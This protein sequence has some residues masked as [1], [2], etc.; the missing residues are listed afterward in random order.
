MNKRQLCHIEVSNTNLL[1]ECIQDVFRACP[2]AEISVTPG[3]E[4]GNYGLTV[5]ANETCDRVELQLAL[6]IRPWRWE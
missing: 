2:E 4:D 1:V 5:M 6:K 3:T